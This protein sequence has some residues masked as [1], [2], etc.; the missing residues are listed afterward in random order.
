MKKKKLKEKTE[1][2]DEKSIMYDLVKIISNV[3]VAFCF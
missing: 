1:G 3:L 2:E